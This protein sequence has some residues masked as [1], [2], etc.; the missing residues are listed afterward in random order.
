M[1][2]FNLAGNHLEE[3]LPSELVYL[4]GL[5]VFNVS[6]NHDLSGTI[7]TDLSTLR[8]EVLDISDTA[9]TRSIPEELCQLD[10][11]Y[12]KADCQELQC[13]RSATQKSHFLAS[14]TMIFNFSF[15]FFT[16]LFLA[17]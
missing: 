8:L 13:C 12:L 7:P 3:S 5:Q 9:M 16:L 15:K 10:Q 17:S 14:D 2:V 6:G 4:L 11:L 1:K